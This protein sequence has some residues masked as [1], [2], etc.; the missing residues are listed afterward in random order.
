LGRR[1]R[2]FLHDT[3]NHVIIE[4]ID[5]VRLFED[6][7]DYEF[8]YE[9]AV[10]LSRIHKLNIHAYNILPSFFEFVATALS[11]EALPKFMQSLGRR[12]TE[13]YN[14]KYDRK[15]TL[16]QGRYK[17]SPIE[18][19]LY[20]FKVMSYV[21]S[22]CETEQSRNAYNSVH[23]NAFAK[24]DSLVSPHKL[25]KELGS[26]DAKR[27]QEYVA[28]K[29]KNVLDDK[30]KE[31]IAQSLN[32]Q[33]LT[34]SSYFA[35]ELEKLIGIS[36]SPRKRGRPKNQKKR[37]TMYKN[38]NLLDKVKHKEL[39]IKPLTDLNFAKEM[40]FIP[41]VA[42][43]VG[44]IATTFPVVF[45]ADET[46]SLVTLVSLGSDSLAIDENGKWIASYLPLAL[47]KYPFALAIP[48]E[49]SNQRVI[50]IDEDAANISTSE[51]NALFNEDGTASETLQKATEFLTNTSK[52]EQIST[53]VIQEIV[54]ADILEE[55]EIAVGEGD[56]KKVL[57][58]GFKVV[59]KEKLNALSDDI[60]ASW[61]RKGII[62][63]IDNHINSLSKVQ[64]LFNLA[65]KK[66]Q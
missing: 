9:N 37:T 64:M 60:L 32:Q 14:K 55:R 16:W 43:E 24:K 11:A 20:L 57:V 30:T 40:K 18:A 36:L 5:G 45:T 7:E 31:F 54:K 63:M 4:A 44:A 23:K 6:P 49:D 1:T 56:A 47:R 52:E 29:A 51:G 53:A 12:Y 15:G 62:T 48:K 66:Q 38:L 35:K 26:T 34:G 39:K 19:K 41:T 25:Y 21:E 33:T 59:N 42:S 17:N 61:A 58:N 2:I 65:S 8:F 50:L 27:A 22:L 46:P 10:H 3:P 13:Y 28:W